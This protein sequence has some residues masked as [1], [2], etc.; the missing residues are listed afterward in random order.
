MCVQG[1]R[2][3]CDVERHRTAAMSVVPCRAPVFDGMDVAGGRGGVPW[4]GCLGGRLARR[5]LPA[6]ASPPAASDPPP[7]QH[8]FPTLLA[9]RGMQ[10]NVNCD[11]WGVSSVDWGQGGAH[12]RSY[13]WVWMAWVVA[14]GTGR[15]TAPS[16][17]GGVHAPQHRWWYPRPQGF[18]PGQGWPIDAGLSGLGPPLNPL[19]CTAMGCVRACLPGNGCHEHA[20]AKDDRCDAP[21]G[22]RTSRTS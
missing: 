8:Y 12:P 7:L 6:S 18:N 21:A 11:V 17:E 22:R 14:A 4:Q 5:G 13:K 20:P 1:S 3:P 16:W 15:E 10:Q 19:A 9:A 2:R